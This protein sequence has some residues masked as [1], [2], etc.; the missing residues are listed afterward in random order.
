MCTRTNIEWDKEEAVVIG[1]P[2]MPIKRQRHCRGVIL[3]KYQTRTEDHINLIFHLPIKET[4]TLVAGNICFEAAP[5]WEMQF[6]ISERVLIE[7]GSHSSGK[8]ELTVG[9]WS[10]ELRRWRAWPPTMKKWRTTRVTMKK[11]EHNR[12]GSTEEEEIIG[13]TDDHRNRY[14]IGA[15]SPATDRRRRR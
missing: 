15:A 2:W 6:G 1:S 10:P 8:W 11:K 9:L 7:M 13:T 12:V 4:H 14:Q 3:I 5:G